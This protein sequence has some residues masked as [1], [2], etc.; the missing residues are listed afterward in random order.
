MCDSSSLLSPDETPAKRDGVYQHLS[1]VVCGSVTDSQDINGN[2]LCHGDLRT[3]ICMVTC[4]QIKAKSWLQTPER[5]LVEIGNVG[6]PQWKFRLEGGL[7]L[8][9]LP[10]LLKALFGLAFGALVGLEQ[11]LEPG[12]RPQLVVRLQPPSI[13]PPA[14]RWAF[15]E[16][17]E[18]VK[19]FFIR[20]GPVLLT[21]RLPHADYSQTTDGNRPQ[22][23]SWKHS[24]TA[25]ES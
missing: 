1:A 4:P 13:E 20:I 7:T 5:W 17:E 18:V 23:L 14:C 21:W 6:R 12:V 24:A 2:L 3:T 10:K 16:A 19:L 22:I 15:H 11:L 25:H 8:K 9:E